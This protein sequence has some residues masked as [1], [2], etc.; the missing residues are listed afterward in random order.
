MR[1]LLYNIRYAVGDGASMRM[2]IPGAGY[3]LGNQ[4]VLGE[5]GLQLLRLLLPL[6]GQRLELHDALGLV[7]DVSLELL[8][9]LHRLAE[10]LLG[11]RVDGGLLAQSLELGARDVARL[12]QV[13]LD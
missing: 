12:R 3:V 10:R 1:L 9:L 7:G 2:P 5:L 6:G 8:V 13:R 4:A 11:L